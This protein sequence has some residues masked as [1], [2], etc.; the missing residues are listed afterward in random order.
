MQLF[1]LGAEKAIYVHDANGNH[2]L[3]AADHITFYAAAVPSAYSKFAKH[4]LYWLIDAGAASPRRMGSIDGSP[5]G[6][7]LA[8][9]HQA[10][11]HYELDQI[12]L[13][14]ARGADSLDRW[15]FP[16]VA[17]GSGFNGGG[18]AKD[19]TLML[20]GAVSTGD[21]TI[22]MYSPYDMQHAT[23]GLSERRPHRHGYVERDRLDRGGVCRSG[24]F[25]GSQ[26]GLTSLRRGFR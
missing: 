15:I 9:S 3:D 17:M 7:P 26:H 4:N 1:Q 12:Y 13:Q 14:S 22:R 5:A 18:V 2:R 6:G 21:L 11:V 25:G 23:S 19:F 8:V 10:T 20:P 24:P 16:T